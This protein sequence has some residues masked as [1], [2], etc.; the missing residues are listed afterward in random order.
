MVAL[1]LALLKGTDVRIL[2]PDLNDNWFVRHASNVYLKELSDMGARVY[3]YDKGFMHQ[4]VM[5]VDDRMAMVGTVN[6]DNR[7][8]RLNFEVTA[9]IA[10]EEF[11]G[12]IESMLRRDLADSWEA[13]RSYFD[14][15]STWERLKSRASALLSPV[16]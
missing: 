11:A 10:N 2:T 9:A 6:F 7:S 3:F 1:R 4:K 16:L 14:N 5:L 13:E 8:F 15:M 12:K